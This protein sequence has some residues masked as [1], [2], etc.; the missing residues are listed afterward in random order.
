MGA[1]PV[2]VTVLVRVKP[3]S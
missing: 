1:H 2:C 3:I